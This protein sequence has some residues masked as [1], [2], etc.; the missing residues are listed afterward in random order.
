LQYLNELTAPGLRAEALEVVRLVHDGTEILLP[1]FYGGEAVDRKTLE[2]PRTT[3]ERKL[4]ESLGATCLP[5]AVDAVRLL[6]DFSKNWGRDLHWPVGEPAVS[7]WFDV[8]GEPVAVWTLRGGPRPEFV[9][10][11]EWLARSIPTE[12]LG[13]LAQRLRQLP[14]VAERF[15]LLEESGFRQRPALS[16][17]AVLAQ[18]GAGDVFVSALR[19]LLDPEPRVASPQAA[20]EPLIPSST[21]VESVSDR[22]AGLMTGNQPPESVGPSGASGPPGRRGRPGPPPRTRR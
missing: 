14:S 4:L 8:A 9:V 10:N 11:F 16:V 20:A 21:P 17:N 15:H 7:A 18:P 12:R 1:R 3:A 6:L 19:E 2:E 5:A 13:R 22:P